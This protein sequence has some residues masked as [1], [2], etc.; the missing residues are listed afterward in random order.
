M[1]NH[2]SLKKDLNKNQANSIFLRVLVLNFKYLVS[3]KRA[4]ITNHKFL[5][6]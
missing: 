2:N 3:L 1:Y 5:M 4:V 6:C